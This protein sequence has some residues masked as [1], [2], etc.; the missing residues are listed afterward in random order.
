[1]NIIYDMFMEIAVTSKEKKG[2]VNDLYFAKPGS[3]YL[4]NKNLLYTTLKRPRKKNYRFTSF[5]T[6]MLKDL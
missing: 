2:A 1:M 6:E 5:Y 4:L 3:A